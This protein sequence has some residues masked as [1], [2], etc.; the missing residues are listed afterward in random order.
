[1]YYQTY[2]GRIYPLKNKKMTFR[3]ERE[4]RGLIY[5]FSDEGL[6]DLYNK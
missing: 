2:N 4:K 5:Q 1:L 3:E 6:F